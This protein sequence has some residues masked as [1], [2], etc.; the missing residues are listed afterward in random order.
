MPEAQSALTD[1]C[2]A[3]MHSMKIPTLL[4]DVAAMRN[5]LD[6]G[7]SVSSGADCFIPTSHVHL[8]PGCLVSDKWLQDP[9]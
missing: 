8:R 3:M 7:L 6:S 2:S 9:D 5:L 4:S 1:A